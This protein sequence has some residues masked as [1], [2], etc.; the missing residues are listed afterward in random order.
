MPIYVYRPGLS[1]HLQVLKLASFEQPGFVKG[2]NIT[3]NFLYAADVVQ[4]C[5]VR[6]TPA[7]VLKLDFK[8]AFDSVSWAAL[9]AILDA[10]G[11]G[12][13]FRLW[14]SSI[15]ST[16]QTAILLNGVP[17]RW[18]RCR[19]GLRQGDPLSPYL[20]LAVADLLPCLIAAGEGADR[21]LHPLVDDLPCPVIQYADDT[22]LILR[23]EHAQVRRL[24][25]VL[26]L[27][28]QATGLQINFHKSTFVPVGGVPE[29]LTLE[30]AAI[31]GCPVSS[32][33]QTYLGLPLSDH[34]LSVAAL[35]FLAVKIYKRIPG[36]RTSLLPIGGR[37]T[38]TTAVLSALPSFAMSVLQI[39]K[40]VLAKMDK[41]RRAM[42]WK[43]KDSCSGGIVRLRGIMRAV[44]GPKVVSG[45]S[46]LVSRTSASC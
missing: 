18:I 13:L 33:P 1:A 34:K 10:R 32:F 39:P 20:Y 15:L 40:G 41:P 37:L 17:G 16:G 7:V 26:D 31:L 46:T 8:K 24:R 9:D 35:E 42:L 25:G 14:I 11:L 4:S 3:D 28:S 2:R 5:H 30:L 45:L 19:N 12:A 44:C 29:G 22:L 27:F 43:A 23:A 6:K 36:W 21:L 38:L